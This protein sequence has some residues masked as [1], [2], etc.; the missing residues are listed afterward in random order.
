MTAEERLANLE[1]KLARMETEKVVRAREFILEDENGKV[2]G[3]LSA[4]GG[5]P[6]LRLYDEKGMLRATL[7]A[8]EYGPGGL[9]LRDAKGKLRAAVCVP[10]L[11]G[12]GVDL[13]D[14]KGKL[15]AAL[16]MTEDVPGVWL[17]DRNGNVIWSATGRS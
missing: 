15:R 11:I 1:Q 5:D 9:F 10:E 12:P 8:T 6:G 3:I 16:G 4:A 17:L 2:R 13:H 14:A 7:D